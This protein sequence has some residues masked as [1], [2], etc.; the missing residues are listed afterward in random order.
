MHSGWGACDARC[1]S[2][3][4]AIGCDQRAEIFRLAVDKGWT[5]LGLQR[6]AQSLD[7]V[8]RDLTKGDE[9]LDRGREWDEAMAE[10]EADSEKESV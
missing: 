9:A 10:A 8:F 4:A 1:D 5:L 2:E 3:P 7:A 6:D